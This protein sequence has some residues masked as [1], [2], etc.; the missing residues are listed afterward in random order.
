[1]LDTLIANV[2]V[3][4]KLPHKNFCFMASCRRT[5]LIANIQLAYRRRRFTKH[6]KAASLLAFQLPADIRRRTISGLVGRER[7]VRDS[8]RAWKTGTRLEIFTAGF[9]VG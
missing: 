3:I 7:D 4:K 2:T 5:P 1:M 9:V 8:E 6:T